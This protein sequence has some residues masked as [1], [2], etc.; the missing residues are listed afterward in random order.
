MSQGFRALHNRNYRLFWIAQIISLSGSWMQTTA[1][2]WLVLQ[3]TGSPLSLG[4]VL[5]L[6]YLPVTLLA[7]YG[8]VLADRLPKRTTL[9]STQAAL[10]VQAVVFGALVA[11]GKIEL[12]HI[13]VL[14][15]IQGLI[16]ALDT[17]IRQSFIM[18][19]VGRDDLLNAVALNSMSFNTARILGPSLAGLIIDLID[20]APTLILNAIS[21]IPVLI[22]LSRMDVAALHTA[23]PAH[24]GSANQQLREGLS[25]AWHSPAILSIL[26]AIAFIGTFGFNF[27]I[28]LPLLARFVLHTNATGFGSLTS[29]LGIGSLCAALFTAYQ[30]D[31]T[32]RRMLIGAGAFSLLLGALALSEVYVLSAALLVAVGFAG[33]I[34]GTASNTLLQL[35]SPDDLR[36]RLMSVH[37]LLF[38]GSTPVG[39]LL[40]GVLSDIAGVQAALVICAALCLLGVGIAVIYYRQP[41]PDSIAHNTPRSTRPD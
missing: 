39:G 41:H 19:M 10:M 40:I 29:F 13:Y 14:A 15:A 31:V 34:Y 30:R 32:M 20:I 33:I 3:I 4:T 22:A 8:G 28:T 12:G 26:I 37:V 1:Q 9:M 35:A 21:F 24:R 23:P 17:P 5:T 38:L 11:S 7:L 18:E 6:Q 25:Y 27:V 16:S 2:A 36:G